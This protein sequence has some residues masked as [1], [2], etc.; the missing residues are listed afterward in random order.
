M[1]NIDA[2]NRFKGIN[3]DSRDSGLYLSFDSQTLDQMARGD[4]ESLAKVALALRNIDF[5]SYRLK[6]P[7]MVWEATISATMVARAGR[8]LQQNTKPIQLKP[9]VWVSESTEL[10]NFQTSNLLEML[11][12]KLATLTD[13]V[14]VLYNHLLG[15]IRSPDRTDTID[16]IRLELAHV[17]DEGVPCLDVGKYLI[18]AERSLVYV[19]EKGNGVAIEEAS[20][21]LLKFMRSQDIV[22]EL[23]TI[24]NQRISEPDQTQKTKAAIRLSLAYATGRDNGMLTERNEIISESISAGI[25]LARGSLK[26]IET[27]F[28][29]NHTALNFVNWIYNRILFLSEPENLSGVE[30]VKTKIV[31]LL[32]VNESLESLLARVSIND[33]TIT[34]QIRLNM[35]DVFFAVLIRGDNNIR[36]EALKALRKLNDP[37]NIARLAWIYAHGVAGDELT[38][39]SAVSL[40]ALNRGLPRDGETP[41][42][43][44]FKRGV[45]NTPQ[46][47]KRVRTAT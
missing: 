20:M 19:L 37:R 8:T 25:N 45:A 15:A 29:G 16:A 41:L 46:G 33:K 40:R 6:D 26:S 28:A 17:D 1:H 23:T 5:E 30:K 3:M 38:N 47:M 11:V 2:N 39:V 18:A 43:V 4:A 35:S 12:K 42:P 32:Q 36:G 21:A 14:S 44:Q 34:T 10:K 13:P 7:Q 22:N 24:L 27:G 9:V 31:Q